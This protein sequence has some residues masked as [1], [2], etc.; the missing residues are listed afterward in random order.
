[1]GD[2]QER[3][4]EASPKRKADARKEGRVAKSQDLVGALVTIVLI[5]ALPGIMSTMGNGFLSAVRNNY[6]TLP[7]D[8]APGTL[9][10]S[11][12][13]ALQPALPGIGL[14]LALTVTVSIFATF[15]QTNFN[16]SF[17]AI[18]PSFQKIDPFQGAKRLFSPQQAMQGVKA[19]LKF[20]LFGMVA[21]RAI[22]DNW[23]AFS[24]LSELPSGAALVMVGNTLRGV[25]MK[26][27][28]V[29][30]VLAALDYIF[31]RKQMDK[32]LKMTK[33]EV[34]RE[35]KDSDGSPEIKA[36]RMQRRRKLMKQ[37]VRDAVKS[38]DV[39]VT[40]PTHY[41]VALKYDPEKSHAP[42]VVAKGVDHLA[43]RIREFAKEDRVPVIPNPRLARALY[44]QCEVGD[45]IPRDLFAAVAELLAYV[46][47]V[48]KPKR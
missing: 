15:L 40:N 28:G 25:A 48:L 13:M 2:G 6:A 14:L 46:Y 27:A 42:I 43:A 45:P 5:S 31:Q 37:R 10:R 19:F 36:A 22:L 47:Q 24:N 35:M 4:E 12:T 16:F 11:L 18:T 38:A 26:I 32:Q 30:F 21:Y 17:K 33:D 3:T 41:A 8:A 23:Q 29:W 34:K 44:K 1:M 9:A 39:I 20:L 7:T